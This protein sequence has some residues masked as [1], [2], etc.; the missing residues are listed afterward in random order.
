MPEESGSVQRAL[1]GLR[2]AVENQ[3]RSID[4]LLDKFDEHVANDE[5]RLGA[6]EIGLAR[7][8]GERGAKDQLASRWRRVAHG[9]MGPTAGGIV[10][11]MVTH[12][13][14]WGPR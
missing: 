9:M 10:G 7:H 13:F 2:E 12:F 3:T 4:R 8:E 1:G 6:I 14:G 11:A 5:R